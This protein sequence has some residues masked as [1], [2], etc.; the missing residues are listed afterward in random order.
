MIIMITSQG[1]DCHYPQHTDVAHTRD[2]A[3]TATEVRDLWATSERGVPIP[4][5]LIPLRAS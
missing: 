4:I 2:S 1:G 3:H 5:E